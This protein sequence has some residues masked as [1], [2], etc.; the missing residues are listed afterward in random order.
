MS[1]KLMGSVYEH[2]LTHGQQSV[3]LAMADHAQD[4]GTD[5]FPSI[6][7]IAWKTGYHKSN[8]KKLFRQLRD[9]GVLLEV[10]EATPHH[11]TEYRIDLGAAPK[12]PPFSRATDPEQSMD[13]RGIKT[14][15]QGDSGVSK[16]EG[17]GSPHGP[18]GVVPSDPEPSLQPSIEPTT[19]CEPEL[20][21]KPAAE[22]DDVAAALAATEAGGEG[23][24]S[25]SVGD[26][27]DVDRDID[28]LWIYYVGLF[29]PGRPKLSPSRAR[30][31]KKGFKEGFTLGDLKLAVLGLKLWRQQKSGDESISTLFTTYPGGQTLA[32]R[33]GFFIDVAEKAGPSGSITSADPAIVQQKQLDVQRGHRSNSPETVQAAQEAEEWLR[34]HGI[35]T[36]R[37][38]DGYPTFKLS[39]GG[40]A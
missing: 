31:I 28:Q 26:G 13:T 7:R 10:R 11:P 35:E 19:T 39:G 18:P 3:L 30:A 2:E 14:Q 6:A 25:M 36:A 12:K 37:G 20:A 27:R 29:N 4:D 21:E 38:D 9:L 40:D 5:C 8:V 17:G 34:Q 32:D 23:Q 15:K 1:G 22:P 24:V 33:I 16:R